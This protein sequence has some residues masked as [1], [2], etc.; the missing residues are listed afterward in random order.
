MLNEIY[1]PT[2]FGIESIVSQELQDLGYSKS[3]IQVSDAEVC[4]TLNNQGEM[5]RA[6]AKLNY[7]LRTAERVL[8]G[9]AKFSAIDFDQLFDQVR[10][11]PWHEWLDKNYFIE[12]TG[13]S[14]KSKLFSVP[15]C[16][17]IIKKAITKQLNSVYK[18]PKN[19]VPENKNVGIHRIQFSIVDDLINIRLDTSGEPLHKRGY[20]PKANEAPIRETLA[21]AIL[22]ISFYQRNIANQEILYDPFCG[23]GTFLIEAALIATK[24]APGMN[25]YFSGAKKKIIGKKAFQQ[26]RKLALE[27]SIIYG[28]PQNYQEIIDKN[29]DSQKNTDSPKDNKFQN[30]EYKR[31][32]YILP[33]EKIRIFGTDI[34]KESIQLAKENAKR[35]DVLD[36][37]HLESKDI[38]QLDY[39]N[40][41]I[42][43]GGDR[44]LIATNP[45]Y[46]ERLADIEEAHRLENKLRDLCFNND[47]ILR[48]GIR[49]SLI[50]SDNEVENIMPQKA[51]K[52]RKLYNGGIRC[53]LFHYFK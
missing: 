1:I 48:Q 25:R 51:N 30:K 23:S 2:L 7:N 9:L 13:Y 15:T 47:E 17:S 12:V 45:P 49:L 44:I 35:A 53:T 46:G 21:A 10:A 11:L 4:L 5:P 14:R 22:M 28:N 26:E 24:T 50:T 33:N 39:Q 31:K 41:P 37:I 3:Q 8:L 52:R 20:R 16:Q 18:Y 38:Y 42:L 32:D 40:L 43:L 27:K 19:I 34:S 36:Y 29:D 6:I